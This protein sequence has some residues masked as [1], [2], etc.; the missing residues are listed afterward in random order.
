[1]SR[2]DALTVIGVGR[3]AGDVSFLTAYGHAG[4]VAQSVAVTALG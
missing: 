4:L 2:A 1:M 3:D